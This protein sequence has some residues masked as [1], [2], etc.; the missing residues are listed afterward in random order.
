[1]TTP[2]P[3]A[4]SVRL[5]DEPRGVHR[6]TVATGSIAD[7]ATIE[8]LS[9]YADDIWVS[10]VVRARELVPVRADTQLHNG[11]SVVIL[12]KPDLAQTLNVLFQSPTP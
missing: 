12:A 8:G 10:I 1:V 4:V 3:W 6:L 11:D 7:G 2:E 9:D 5:R